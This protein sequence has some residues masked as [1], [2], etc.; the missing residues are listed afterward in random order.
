MNIGHIEGGTNAGWRK[1]KPAR[2]PFTCACGH[3]NPRYV[4][5]CLECRAPRVD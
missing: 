3:D 1:M 4:T 5:K 2:T